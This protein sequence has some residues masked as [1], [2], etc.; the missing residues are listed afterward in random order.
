[1]SQLKVGGEL[2]VCAREAAAAGGCT[3]RNSN[4]QIRARRSSADFIT[5]LIFAQL[6]WV[7]AA[8]ARNTQNSA[9]IFGR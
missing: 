8:D 3:Y 2:G 4:R 6:E 5:L 7:L 9:C 1:M